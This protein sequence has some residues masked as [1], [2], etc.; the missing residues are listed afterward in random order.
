MN[1][2]KSLIA[3]REIAANAKTILVPK[4]EDNRAYRE[5]FSQATDIEIPKFGDRRLCVEAGKRAFY[6]VKAIDI[7]DLVAMRRTWGGDSILPTERVGVVGSDVVIE[8]ATSTVKSMQIG[9]EVCRFA[10]LAANW[11]SRDILSEEQSW[12]RAWPVITSYPR[13]LTRIATDSELPLRAVGMTCWED[14]YPSGSSEIMPEL[15]GA[16]F[17]A[18]IVSSGTTAAV[19]GKRELASLMSI[20]PELVWRDDDPSVTEP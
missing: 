9:G 14:I 12:N 6:L 15:T 1:T 2:Y 19:N 8:R 10:L 5:A 11:E 20:V 3:P 7:P 4:G 16:N 18:D 17:V 13:L